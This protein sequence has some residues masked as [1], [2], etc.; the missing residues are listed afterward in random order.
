M[1]RVAGLDDL[2]AVRGHEEVREE[3]A[4]LGAVEYVDDH[5]HAANLAEDLARQAGGLEP[6]RDDAEDLHVAR[7]PESPRRRR[8]ALWPNDAGGEAPS[9][10]S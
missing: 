9:E 1:V 5:G 10:Y 8:P 7:L 4:G 2:L 3:P 6:C